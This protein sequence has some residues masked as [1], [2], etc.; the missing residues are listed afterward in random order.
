M[1]L[2][3][4]LEATALSQWLSISMLGFPTLI[5]LHSVGMAV[6]VGL[7][8]IVALRLNGVVVTGIDGQLVA[9]LLTIAAWGFVLNFVTGLALFITRGAD[10]ITS[11]IFLIKMLL[12]IVSA[13]ILFWLRE[14]LEPVDSTSRALV[15][16]RLARNLSLVAATL[17]FAAVVAGRLIAY[18]SDLYR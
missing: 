5:A 12:V 15:A 10:Y 6:V 1:S 2:L 3:A 16:D 8:L 18:L 11:G 4:Y 14:R 13:I 9:K 17:W 7:S